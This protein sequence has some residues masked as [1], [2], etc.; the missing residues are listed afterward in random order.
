VTTDIAAATAFPSG[1]RR[2]GRPRDAAVEERII[3]AALRGMVDH[4]IAGLSIE[5]VAADAEVAKTTIYRRWPTKDSLVID[6]LASLK[7]P[8]PEVD[9]TRSVR[10]ELVGLIDAMRRSQQN[11][12]AAR[13]MPC[14][15]AE[16]A[17]L[18]ELARQYDEQVIEPRRQRAYD[19]LRRGIA[20][21]EFRSDIDV[22]LVWLLLIAPTLLQFVGPT[23]KRQGPLPVDWAER[24]VDAVISGI[25]KPA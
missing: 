7:E 11:A 12:L 20:T 2:P 22:R 24:L 1:P 13:L 15:M 14:M 18:P 4:G 5:A 6:A 21:G 3:Q 17:Q 9:D 10:D 19:T 16:A 8:M 23:M 25:G